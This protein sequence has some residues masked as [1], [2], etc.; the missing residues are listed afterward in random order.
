LNH[1]SDKIG[2]KRNCVALLSCNLIGQDEIVYETLICYY[3]TTS[4]YLN[5]QWTWKKAGLDAVYSQP[6]TQ[7]TFDQFPRLAG[8][9]KYLVFLIPNRNY[10]I[11]LSS[12]QCFD[13]KGKGYHINMQDLST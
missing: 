2:H 8:T 7:N 13:E 11:K 4:L 1:I 5:T 9:Q 10:L 12:V 3:Y 6:T